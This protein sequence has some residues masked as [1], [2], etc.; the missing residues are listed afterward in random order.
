MSFNETFT[1]TIVVA[2]IIILGVF[3]IVKLRSPQVLGPK[4]YGTYQYGPVAYKASEIEKLGVA[5]RIMDKDYTYEDLISH[6]PVLSDLHL[7][8]LSQSL[9]IASAKVKELPKTNGKP[10]VTLYMPKPIKGFKFDQD[11]SDFLLEFSNERPLNVV[12]SIDEK[13]YSRDELSLNQVQFSQIK[14]QQFY[15]NLRV[16]TNLYVR[17]LLLHAAK[18]ENTTIQSLIQNKILSESKT[19]T[20]S[21]LQNFAREKGLDFSK[22][23]Q[24]LKRKIAAIIEEKDRNSQIE[25][26][27]KKKFP[28]ETGTLFFYPPQ[29][30]LP[31]SSKK[32]LTEPAKT[33]D[34]RPLLMAF[35]KMQCN[36]CQQLADDLT[37]LRKKYKDKIKVGFVHFFSESDWQSKLAAEASHCIHLQNQDAF[38]DFFHKTSRIKQPLSEALIV[39]TAKS[40]GIDFENFKTCFLSQTY[41][42]EVQDQMKFAKDI[43]V[44]N[45]PAL[46]I[47]GQVFTDTINKEQIIDAIKNL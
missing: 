42:N 3:A 32:A 26:Y 23:S 36:N 21:D 31:I 2:T 29:Y 46:I 7:R 9:E 4:I 13:S 27:L 45:T 6:S 41:K 39:E 43:G 20:D 1:K 28:N 40:T 30:Q 8:E 44:A 47:G 15:E 11:K 25:K 10:K 24:E 14:T 12:L 19:I 16:L 35:T 18:S 22:N 17:Q 34:K 38:W 5:A 37:E 33:N